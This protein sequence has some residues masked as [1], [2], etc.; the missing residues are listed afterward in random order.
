MRQILTSKRWAIILIVVLIVSFV[1]CFQAAQY[2]YETTHLDVVRPTKAPASTVTTTKEPVVVTV[3]AATNKPRYAA[4]NLYSKVGMIT[5]LDAAKDEVIF[6]D[7]RGMVWSFFGV[8][9][10]QEGDLLCAI[11][12]D[13]DTIDPYDDSVIGA[14]YQAWGY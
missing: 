11:F 5:R 3:P 6:T 12:Y 7:T 9:D 13:A 1:G 2:S 10:W 14:T 4:S 8:E